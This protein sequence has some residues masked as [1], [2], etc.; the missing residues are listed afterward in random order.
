MRRFMLLAGMGMAMI[1]ANAC[2]AASCAEAVRA[3]KAHDPK[4]DMPD[5]IAGWNALWW[6]R[7]HGCQEVLNVVE[8]NGMRTTKG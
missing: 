7:F 2:G 8:P 6:A 3:L 5:T 4:V 1:A